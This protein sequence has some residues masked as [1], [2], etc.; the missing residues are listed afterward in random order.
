MTSDKEYVVEAIRGR[1]S[2][3]DTIQYLIK[4]EGW[5]ETSNTWEDE[6]NLSDGCQTL[7]ADYLKKLYEERENQRRVK[8]LIEKQEKRERKER[9]PVRI[10]GH[11]KHHDSVRFNILLRSGKTKRYSLEKARKKVPELLIDYLEGISVFKLA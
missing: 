1:R 2:K 7:I 10:T 8:V 5:P 3:N 4:W 11:Q 9:K 6:S